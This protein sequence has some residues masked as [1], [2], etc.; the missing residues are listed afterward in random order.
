MEPLIEPPDDISKQM[1]SDASLSYKLLCAIQSG[2]LSPELASMKCGRIVNSRWL[3]TGQSIMMLWM[4]Q[5][6]FTEETLKE[7]DELLILY[8]TFILPCS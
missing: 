1:S 4:S 8:V 5:H 3:T 6:E 7:S 2:E